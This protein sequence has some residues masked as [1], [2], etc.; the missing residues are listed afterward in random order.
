[1][2]QALRP[3]FA[4][5]FDTRRDIVSFMADLR[6]LERILQGVGSWNLWKR[7]NSVVRSDLNRADLSGAVLSEARAFG[8]RA[9]PL[10]SALQDTTIFPGN[11][12]SPRQPVDLN[13]QARR[14]TKK[15]ARLC[16]TESLGC[17]PLP[18]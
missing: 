6:Q 13:I 3:S 16:A 5:H 8:G 15:T 2:P 18:E 4:T 12:A 11:G 17:A 9:R 7:E 1:M 14:T 10:C